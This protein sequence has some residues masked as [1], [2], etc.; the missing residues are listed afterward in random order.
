MK[1][2]VANYVARCL[3]CQ[4]VKVEDQRPMGLLQPLDVPE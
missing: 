3:T 4:R 1:Q 2:E